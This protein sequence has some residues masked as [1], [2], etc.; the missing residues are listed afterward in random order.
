MWAKLQCSGSSFFTAG[1][2][3]KHKGEQE[4]ERHLTN[5]IQFYKAQRMEKGLQEAPGDIG[6]DKKQEL[7]Q[8]TVY[9]IS[10]RSLNIVNRGQGAA[11]K[12]GEFG[13]M[14]A[15]GSDREEE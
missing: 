10:F 4:K 2:P 3:V 9:S 7:W 15:E 11:E 8:A 6:T 13:A 12:D 5:T 1:L 14:K